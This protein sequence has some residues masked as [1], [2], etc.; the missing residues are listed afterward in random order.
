MK[1]NV[2]IYGCEVYR[3]KV[4]G[5]EISLYLIAKDVADQFVMCC[6][7]NEKTNLIIQISVES[8]MDCAFVGVLMQ[9]IYD[10]IGRYLFQRNLA[11]FEIVPMYR[12]GGE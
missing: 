11:G 7:H 10:E 4:Y 5:G 3:E 8:F 1:I 2:C 6:P 9:Q 12:K